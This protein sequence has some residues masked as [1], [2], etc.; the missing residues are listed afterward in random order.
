MGPKP[1][2][3]PVFR[4]ALI[5]ES[6]TLLLNWLCIENEQIYFS[7]YFQRFKYGP[8][9]DPKVGIGQC[10]KSYSLNKILLSGVYSL[11]NNAGKK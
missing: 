7:K 2:L 6:K 3:G 4:L 8:K 5:Y 10:F 1:I 11:N 9:N